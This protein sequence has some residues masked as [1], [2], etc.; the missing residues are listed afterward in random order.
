MI[1]QTMIFKNFPY[2]LSSDIEEFVQHC[3]KKSYKK[4]ELLVRN[5][6]ICKKVYL[7]EEGI[8]RSFYLAP[9]DEEST[10]CITFPGSFITAYSSL[11]LQIP[12][13]ENIQAVTDI[14]V[15]EVPVEVIQKL[16]ANNIRWMRFLKDM[17]EYQ[18]IELEQR[19]HQLQHVPAITRYESLLEQ[20]P[21]YVLHLPVN[22]LSSY[23]GITPRHLN[24]IRK[25]L[26]T[27]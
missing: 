15:T 3:N 24:R 1:F 27:I 9:N 25:S 10:Y 12:T 5:G 19:L 11:I 13:T 20:H 14:E 21:E 7:V 2:L 4:G 22:Y 18:Y 8:V 16:S 17:A 26:M 6:M 23:L